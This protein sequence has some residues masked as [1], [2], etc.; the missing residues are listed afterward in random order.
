VPLKTQTTDILAY[1]D[2][3]W[4]TPRGVGAPQAFAYVLAD[5]IE[6]QETPYE[7]WPVRNRQERTPIASQK[8]AIIHE[9]DGN[10]C[11]YCGADRV[12]LTVDHIIPRS[13]FP[14]DQLHIAD[15]SDNLISACWSCNEGKS[16]YERDQRKRLGV[17][18]ACFYCTHP[19][20]AE[21]DNEVELP[22]SVRVLVFCGRCGVSTVPAVEG[23][24]L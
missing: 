19:E 22:Y 8:R 17:T 5:L 6:C 23:W 20:Y 11:R 10:I 13:A 1:A 4:W 3:S 2:Q 24:V 21:E 14:A 18:L 15:R 16:N 9:R 7:R 12:I